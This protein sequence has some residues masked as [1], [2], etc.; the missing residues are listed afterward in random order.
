LR[1][2]IKY[3]VL[4][5][6]LCNIPGFLLLYFGPA[7]GSAASYLTSLSLL[8][9]FVIS[10]E[11]QR[12]P[13]VFI[14]FTALYFII[15]G[16]NY[17]GDQIYYIKEFIRFSIVLIGVTAVMH[18]SNYSD[19]FYI[20]LLAGLSIIINALVFPEANQLYGLVRGRFSGFLLNP[21]TAGIVCLL[22]M[23]LSYSIKNSF[24]KYS[25]QIIFTFAGLLTL[26]RT[27][28][29]IWVLLNIIAIVNNR[30]N[31]IVPVLGVLSLI[32]VLTFVDDSIFASDRFDALTS[33]FTEGEVKSR[34]VGKD[35]R[36]QTWALYYDLILEKPVFGHG[37]MSFQDKRGYYLPGVHNSF[38]MIFGES[39]ILPFLVFLGI[40][41]YLSL[42]SFGYFKKE[43]TLFYITMV[44][45]LNLMVSH[46]YFTN[47][48]MIS[49][50]IYVLLKLKILDKDS[51]SLNNPNVNLKKLT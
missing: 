2:I 34:T 15:S 40:Y 43:P 29:V 20:F 41:I 10:K 16:L 9:Y 19:I 28:I 45:L 32:I 33:F 1:E 22:G 24:W 38:L 48:Q 47:Y 6:V 23:A 51:H 50:S 25:G 36:D 11:K 3:L 49:L 30:K 42:K 27:F 17:S 12:P 39:G 46:T 31:L 37:F 7:F 4:F 18:K 14:V 5:L 44:C 35:T 21:N 8:L 26:S 13:I